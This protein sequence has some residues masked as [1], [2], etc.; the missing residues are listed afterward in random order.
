M[1]KRRKG[2]TN[3]INTKLLL[4]TRSNLIQKGRRGEE[5]KNRGFLCRGRESNFGKGKKNIEA[6]GLEEKC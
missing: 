4:K 6:K 3:Y 2:I 1:S 5:E